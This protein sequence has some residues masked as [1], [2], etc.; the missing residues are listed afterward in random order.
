VIPL[1]LTDIVM[2]LHT[3][4]EGAGTVLMKTAYFS[5]M[6]CALNNYVKRREGTEETLLKTMLG[7][8]RDP[9]AKVFLPIYALGPVIQQT[10]GHTYASGSAAVAS[11]GVGAAVGAAVGR[12]RGYDM[13]N[14][15]AWGTFS[16]QFVYYN[17]CALVSL[18][19]KYL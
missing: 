13:Q 1:T 6:I 10:M 18:L 19:E 4:L 16:G 11:M 3:G 9:A 2:N 5:S 15:A 8:L 7:D 14:A 17:G 12:Y